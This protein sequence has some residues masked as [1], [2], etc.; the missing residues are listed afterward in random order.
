[1]K[2]NL[3]LFVLLSFT[4]QAQVNTVSYLKQHIAYL[5]SDELGGRG[6]GTEGEKKAA[7]YLVDQY[8]KM[9]LPSHNTTPSYFQT[10]TAR[11]GIHPFETTVGTQNIIAFLDNNSPHTVVVGAHY[12]HLGTDGQ[13]SSLAGQSEDKIHNGADDNASGTAGVLELARYLTENA[14]KE[15]YNYLFVHFAAEELG[16][17]GSKHF[18]QNSPIPL[19]SI[20]YMINM[21]MI[22]RYSDDKGLTVG[23]VGTS[24]YWGYAVPE[25][26]KKTSLRV[27]V[28]STGMGPSDHASFYLQNIPVLSFFTGVHADYHKPSDDADKI[29]Y[30]G[31]AQVID[32]IKEIISRMEK[33]DK[34]PFTTTIIPQTMSTQSSFKVTM[35]VIPDYSYDKKGLRL[36][37]V[38]EGRPAANAGMKT[39]DVLIHLG[40]QTID[41]IQDYMEALGQFEK[42]QT[43]KAIVLRAGKPIQVSVTF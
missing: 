39:S 31:Q 19:S 20:H 37:G 17:V 30:L 43:V 5:A 14:I 18:V 25:S 10:L 34:A 41:D 21:D 32:F 2:K 27:R 29:N 12:D 16:L 4:S 36:D 26:I 28:D 23:G 42:G 11:K 15:K 3:F 13:G 7:D 1:M 35:G 38:T 6:S 22:G 33:V 40:G 24:P 8:K 9:G